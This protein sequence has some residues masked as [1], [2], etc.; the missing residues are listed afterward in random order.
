V[1][2]A[3][4]A[5]PGLPRDSVRRLRTRILTWYDQR[6]RDLPWRREPSLYGTWV[7]EMML[8][9]TTVATVV[10]FW[11]RFMARFPDVASLAAAPTAEV[12]AHWSGLGYYR[13]AHNLQAAARIIA[14]NRAGRLPR[15]LEAWRQ[16]PGVG[17]YAAGAIASIGLG[18]RVP[19]VDANVRR[20]LT[21]LL[22]ADPAAAAVS[23]AHLAAVAADLVDPQRPGDWNQ[24]LMELGAM[25]CRA[26]DPAC[27]DCPARDGC[28]AAGGGL[29][30]AVGRLPARSPQVKVLLSALLVIV[31]G[32]ALLLPSAHVV[33]TAVPGL[34]R[35]LRDDF[36]GLHPGL[37]APPQTAWYGLEGSPDEGVLV[38]AWRRWLR[39]GGVTSPDL[40]RAGSVGHT[41]THHR[42][43]IE[44]FRI[45]VSPAESTLLERELAPGR[46]WATLREG[47]PPGD[48]LPLTTPAR[49]CLALGAVGPKPDNMHIF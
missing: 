4:R 1:T 9:Q 26:R 44:V 28:R 38:R 41:I 24:A 2:T 40:R 12:L 45:D 6:R 14:E 23:P 25:V 33:V 19:A 43:R 16:L 13:R 7:S 42:L 18:L 27:G 35:P 11:Q 15:T 21:R 34:G 48:I 49:R 32:R 22:A 37:F 39:A 3:P 29:A 10:P 8:Q 30:A 5:T 31:D 17:P 36:G 20:V 46:C 47:E